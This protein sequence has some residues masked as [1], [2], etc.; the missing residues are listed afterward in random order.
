MDEGRKTSGITENDTFIIL[1]KIQ[2]MRQ[3]AYPIMMRW[4]VA[5]KYAIGNDMM[6]CM[7]ELLELAVAVRWKH[8]K[9]TTLTDLD[10]K[11]KT[12]QVYI[13]DAFE[14][15]ILKGISSYKEWTRRSEEI[16]KLIGGY[17]Q[18]INGAAAGNTANQ[19]QGTFRS[20]RGRYYSTRK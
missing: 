8:F 9:K 10:I 17:I 7:N 18:T 16:G 15:K 4:S 12:L 5:E 20:S 1:Q 11:N 19:Q 2:D 6:H 3:Y 14:L 13:K